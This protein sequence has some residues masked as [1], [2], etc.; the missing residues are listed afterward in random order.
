[1][2]IDQRGGGRDLKETRLDVFA[3]EPTK[4]LYVLTIGDKQSQDEDIRDSIAF[5]DQLQAQEE[6][7]DGT[8]IR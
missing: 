3:F 1:M 5:V 6:P 8:P 2:A 4:T 7:R